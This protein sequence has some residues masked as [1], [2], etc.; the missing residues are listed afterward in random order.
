MAVA[1]VTVDT[2]IGVVEVVHPHAN[3][4]NVVT[5][6][7]KD[8]SLYDEGYVE[9]DEIDKAE[10]MLSTLANPD[11]GHIRA[12]IFQTLRASEEG[13]LAPRR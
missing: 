1:E 11:V 3:H 6:L 13:R 8:P 10:F 5:T 2:E 9:T 7:M 4:Y 12:L